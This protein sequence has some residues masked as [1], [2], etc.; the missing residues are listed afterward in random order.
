MKKH[1]TIIDWQ[2]LFFKTFFFDLSH[3]NPPKSFTENVSSSTM[4]NKPVGNLNT[5]F[6]SFYSLW[7]SLFL[8]FSHQ[9][10]FSNFLPFSASR[11][12]SNAYHFFSTRTVSFNQRSWQS[13]YIFYLL[14]LPLRLA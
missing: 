12:F 10:L 8:V 13:K 2:I 4:L 5:R 14:G 6:S 9:S 11:D 7:L 3:E 1:S